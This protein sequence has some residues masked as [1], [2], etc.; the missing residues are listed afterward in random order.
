VK[1]GFETWKNE[2]E[3]IISLIRKE[4]REQEKRLKE[5]ENEP[6]KQ[7]TTKEISK[8]KEVLHLE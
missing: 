2:P 3:N 7:T 8:Q 4:I 6:D 5:S 1:R